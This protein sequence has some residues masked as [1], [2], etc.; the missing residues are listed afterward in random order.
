[1]EFIARI[2]EDMH[3]V[4]ILAFRTFSL[5]KQTCQQKTTTKHAVIDERSVVLINYPDILDQCSHRSS[6]TIP[7]RHSTGRQTF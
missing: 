6:V 2:A 4:A 1:V 7:F 5:M 3:E